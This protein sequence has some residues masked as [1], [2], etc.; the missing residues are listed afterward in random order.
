MK[1]LKIFKTTISIVAFAFLAS[2]L[3]LVSCS[4]KDEPIV[5]TPLATEQDPLTGYLAASGFNQ[6]TEE[7]LNNIDRELGYSFIPLVNGK[8][9]AI[10]VK[11]PDT[12]TALKVTIWDKANSS[13]IRTETI[14]I[15]SSGVETIKTI[16]PVNLIKDKEYVISMNSND[17]YVHTKT[18]GSSA[19]YPFVIGDIKVTS[20][21][22]RGGVNQIIPILTSS[23]AYAGDCS[24]KFQK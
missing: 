16:S 21:L 19:T 17:Y 3:L 14:D 12:R 1:N 24:F 9:T 6:N 5:A 7:I 18:N 22:E 11:I 15:T 13:V 23:P 2:T 8:I 20:F 4:K 10:V